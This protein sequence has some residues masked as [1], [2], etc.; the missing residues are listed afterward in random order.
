MDKDEIKDF[1]FAIV[2]GTV[3]GCLIAAAMVF[4][5]WWLHTYFMR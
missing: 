5:F 1:I 2:A 4:P 3:S